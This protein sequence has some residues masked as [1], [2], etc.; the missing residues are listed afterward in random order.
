MCLSRSEKFAFRLYN[1]AWGMI[2]P[3]L[4]YNRR[5]AEGF[6]QRTFEKSPPE[7]VDIWIQAASVGESFLARGLIEGLRA[8]RPLHVL[9]TSNTDQGMHILQQAIDELQSNGDGLR[10][11]A[12][13]FPFDKP[14]I[15]RAAVEHLRPRVMV[16]LETEIWP[17]LLLG[18]KACGSR[19]MIING[20]LTPKSFKRYRLWPSIWRSL[21]PDRVLAT[22]AADAGRYKA[23][24]GSNGIATMPNIKFDRIAVRAPADPA[25]SHQ[26]EHLLPPEAT[27][28]ILG[29]IR[30]QEEPWIVKIIKAILSSRKNAVI[31]LFPRH[32]HRIEHWQHILG[33]A[34]FR[35]ILRSSI[36]S[37][38]PQGC[39]VLWDTFG[40]LA[41]AYRFSTAAFVGGSLAP[42]GGQ[43]FLEALVCGAI[44]VIG[45]S[46]ENFAW[47]GPELPAS[48]LLKVAQDWKQVADQ[49][50][51]DIDHPAPHR[52]VL[53]RVDQ[54][55]KGRRGG[56]EIACRH[57]MEMLEA[58][59]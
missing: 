41:A 17:G 32:Q 33:R 54:Y 48:G 50:I 8:I 44:P 18:L 56:T 58:R 16:L 3:F 2:I 39:V 11:Q 13:F 15:M 49:L 45:P 23:L 4:R 51:K 6:E 35:W 52:E 43:N 10:V 36:Q 28:V 12:A 34:Q 38:V 7:G 19:I 20:R 31:G 24:F 37:S 30:R 59:G 46:W 9:L 14:D 47:V 42:L 29:S 27:F 26:L 21:S 55:L 57:I 40:E 1:L 22:S 25:P 5:L 53:E